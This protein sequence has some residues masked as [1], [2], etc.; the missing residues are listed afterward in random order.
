MKQQVIDF[1][2][3]KAHHNDFAGDLAQNLVFAS[4]GGSQLH[5]TNEKDSDFDI[6]AVSVLNDDYILGLKHFEHYKPKSGE[7][8]ITSAGDLDVEVFHYDSFIKRVHAGEANTV[9]MIHAPKNK[10]IFMDKIFEPIMDHKDLFFSKQLVRHYKGLIFRHHNQAQANPKKLQKPEKIA[11]IMKYGYETKEVMKCILFLRI[12]IEFLE[13]G[14]LNLYREDRNE[15]LGFKNGD[16]A[17]FKEA[18]TY[19]QELVKKRD[20]LYLTSRIPDMPDFDKL[21]AFMKEYQF[22]ILQHIGIVPNTSIYQR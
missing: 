3:S 13:T 21:N 18:D 4:Y 19:I 2:N 14:V 1:L 7:G 5:G 10:I 11:R 6:R 8:G 20:E 12:T 16:F 9:E 15:L 17:T 22:M